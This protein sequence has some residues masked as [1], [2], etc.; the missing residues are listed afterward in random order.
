MHLH[1]SSDRVLFAVFLRVSVARCF[2]LGGF[3]GKLEDALGAEVDIVS[4]KA[5]SN[6]FSR[7]VLRDRRLPCEA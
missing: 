2:K 4:E 1:F 5:M 6:D 3:Y 7:E